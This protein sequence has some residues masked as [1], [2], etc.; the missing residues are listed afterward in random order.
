M[1]SSARS[2]AERQLQT[3]DPVA[4]RDLGRAIKELKVERD[5]PVAWMEKHFII[6]DTEAPIILARHQKAILSYALKRRRDGR[7][8]F[9]TIIYSAPKKSGKTAVAGAVTRWAAETWGKYGE[10]LC[11]GN[12]A[13]QA[14]ERA[15]KAMRISI[16]LTP[17]YS[18]SSQMLGNRWHVL[19]KEAKCL[20]TGTIV[21]AIAT[22]Y[23]GEAG[24]NPIL[25]VW[26]E[27]W[28]FTL[29][30]D[31]RFWAEMA[32]SPTRPDSVQWI[33]TYAGYEG[34]SELL[35]GLY[36]NVV[37]HGRQLTAGEL[38]DLDAF[39]EAPNAD[40]LVPCYVN[41]R[42]GVFAYWDE[43]V[44]ARRMPWQRGDHG[45]KYYAG[46]AVRQT[47]SQM[48]RLHTNAWVSAESAFIAIEWW[49][50]AVNPM[51]LQPQERTPLVIALDAAVTG[52]CFGL[53]V[54]SRTPDKA[55][56]P[57]LAVR[58]VQKWDP[59]PGG[60][61]NYRGPEQVVRQLCQDYNVVQVAYD[62]F[63][64]H[65]FATRLQQETVAWFR[66]FSQAQER[67]IADKGLYDLI[68]ARRIRHDGNLDLR[69]HLTN[70]NAKQAANEDTRLRIVKKSDT[71]K[72]DLA[73]CLS[74]AS[75]ELLRL[76]L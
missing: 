33:E 26:T 59:P 16:E 37:T 1:T 10:I 20:T 35:W 45:N 19:T 6:E 57:N 56:P 3:L 69:E 13:E 11:V 75:K 46:E 8:P 31:L 15:F 7:L 24:A 55:T 30:R 29:T 48:V 74:M 71:R 70:A 53:L 34:E 41:E 44:Q 47:A 18:P 50:A 61:I 28:G 4:L 9:N 58:F 39:E 17:G 76:M 63:Q 40:S 21:K 36:D 2:S 62:P 22:D 64:L 52:D 32:P 38:G 51:P 54:M 5:D 65:D 12:D 72:I 23:K 27:L 68:V 49:D 60:A 25:V 43:G 14:K 42:A 73:V 66:S 67:L